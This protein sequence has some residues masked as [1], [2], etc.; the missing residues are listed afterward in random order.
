M[1]K[2][3]LILFCLVWFG[4]LFSQPANHSTY[5]WQET[6][7]RGKIDS[8]GSW[9]Y[10][11]DFKCLSELSANHLRGNSGT[12]T[13]TAG[14]GAGTT[15]TI[16]IIGND[17]AGVISLTTGASPVANSTVMTVAYSS[18]YSTI[19]VVILSHVNSESANLSTNK[20]YVN[21][22]NNSISSFV[23]KGLNGLP[24]NKV[25]I[26]CYHIFN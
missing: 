19:P 6:I 10:Y 17:L 26:W 24:A 4:I 14:T 16:S 13:F 22:A 25:F 23:I 2:I 7:V 11:K 12:P 5:I 3:F 1:K 20:V 18:T 8:L 15:S 21:Q 9:T